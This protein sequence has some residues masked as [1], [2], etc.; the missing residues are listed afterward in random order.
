MRGWTTWNV[1]ILRPVLHRILDHAERPFPVVAQNPLGE[2]GRVLDANATVTEITTGARE[3]LTR[4]CVVKVN[5][6]DIG[7]HELHTAE[8]VVRTWLLPDASVDAESRRS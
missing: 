1:Y 4:R 8:G 2:C 5:V 7:K 3:Q 6:H